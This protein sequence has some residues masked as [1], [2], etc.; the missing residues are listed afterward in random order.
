MKRELTLKLDLS[1]ILP[2]AMLVIGVLLWVFDSKL[3]GIIVFVLG[4]A[5]FVYLHTK[6]FQKTQRYA[7]AANFRTKSYDKIAGEITTRYIEVRRFPIK[8]FEDKRYFVKGIIGERTNFVVEVEPEVWEE[9]NE[10]TKVHLEALEY[11]DKNGNIIPPREWT[12]V[13]KHEE[14]VEIKKPP[15]KKG[16]GKNDDSKEKPVEKAGEK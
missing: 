10:G 13:W 1:T 2:L 16:G 11:L 7:E 5:L 6:K 14:P 3:A 9:L 15:K 12:R 8:A 4:V